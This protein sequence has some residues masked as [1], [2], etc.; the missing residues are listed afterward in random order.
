MAPKIETTDQ[1][2]EA[3]ATLGKWSRSV[4][5]NIHAGLY[6]TTRRRWSDIR[7]GDVAAAMGVPISTVSVTIPQLVEQGLVGVRRDKTLLTV[8]HVKD[9]TRRQGATPDDE[10]RVLKHVREI[11]RRS[12]HTVAP[13]TAE[14]TTI[15]TVEELS[16]ALAMHPG[17]VRRHLHALVKRE[18]LVWH[19]NTGVRIRRKGERTMASNKTSKSTTTTT[20]RKTTKESN[21]MASTA[22]KKKAP[23]R[24]KKAAANPPARKKAAGARKAPAK[25]AAAKS[26]KGGRPSKY[27]DTIKLVANQK[28]ERREGSTFHFIAHSC[29]KAGKTIPQLVQHMIDNFTTKQGVEVDQKFAR[30]WVTGAVKDKV[31][32][33][34]K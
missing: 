4:Y 12:E 22:T 8:E 25:K 6:D 11:F 19:D 27:D 21:T 29:G 10:M 7:A 17:S 28:D 18:F 9:L 3:L 31:I 13:R 23:A 2:T 30:A 32:I 24:R 15:V 20:N 5:E 14:G 34:K 1:L 26:G 16:D 33:A